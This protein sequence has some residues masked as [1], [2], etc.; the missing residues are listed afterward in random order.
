MTSLTQPIPNR[1][2]SSRQ[3]R[4]FKKSVPLSY[5]KEKKNREEEEVEKKKYLFFAMNARAL[6]CS[7][8]F[9]SLYTSNR[10]P[11]K[12]S[13]SRNLKPAPK[14]LRVWIY[15]R[16][17]SSVFRVLVRSTDKRESSNSYYVDGE[18]VNRNEVVSDST[19][20]VV[21]PWWE[22]FPKRWV[23]VLLCFSAFLLCNMDRVSRKRKD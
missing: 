23:I 7:P 19:S 11:E 22:E 21:L 9:H 1:H 5:R 8:N 18:R 12:S 2:M 13:S 17:R 4:P 10:P 15:P 16:N 6:L 20:S 14:S 3:P